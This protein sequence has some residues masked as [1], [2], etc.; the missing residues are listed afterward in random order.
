M[1][2]KKRKKV[3]KVVDS[4][5]EEENPKK[6]LKQEREDKVEKT[7]K[8]L[9]TKH[10][11]NYSLMQ[12]RIWS[13]MVANGMHTDLDNP[14]VSSMFKRAGSSPQSSS[15]RPDVAKAFTSSIAAVLSAQKSN[16]QDGSPLKKIESRSKCY[17]QLSEL[18]NL[19]EQG[20]LTYD[21]Y[22]SEK[23]CILGLLKKL[24]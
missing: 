6:S 16:N 19:K 15:S 22:I 3:E 7:L 12:Y 17:K 13:E 9:K 14:P 20:L 18:N 2:S 8:I 4:D 5:S 1:V 23:Q 24:H 11:T 10:S 21:D